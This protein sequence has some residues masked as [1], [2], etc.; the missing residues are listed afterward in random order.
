MYYDPYDRPKRRRS[1][2]LGWLLKTLFKLIALLLVLTIL[3]AG[4]LY[5]APISL[6]Q[7]EPDADVSPAADLPDSP[8]NLLIL[9]VDTLNNGL[10]RSDTMMI[11]SVG[12]NNLVLSSLQ[13]DVLVDL[14]GHGSCKL[15][16]AYAF[17]GAPMAMRAVN[18]TY[19][20]NVVRYIVV[21]FTV[22]VRIVDAIGGID[23]DIT[24]AEMQQINLNV[25]AS[26]PIF[27]PLGYTAQPL[28]TWG[29]KTHL[30]GLQA[31]GYARIRKIDSDFMRTSRQRRVITA[32][33]G[34][35]KAN[36][37]NPLVIIPTA[38]TV[39]EGIDTDLNF[40][41][42]VMVAEKV[43]SAKEITQLRLPVDGS[44]SDNG[45]SL[46]I[47]DYDASARAF[48]QAVYQ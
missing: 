5:I 36:L 4:V 9:G 30:D 10:Q 20:T 40:V 16:A 41:E 23:I 15:N 44:F 47:T 26:Y 3:A 12:G 29:E 43:L 21:D 31:L 11:A 38:K 14:E 37:F 2:C 19:R 24:E 27:G 28:T 42:L 13:R 25:V 6:L 46:K 45:S 8:L 48:R 22:L 33:V 18:Q 1:G 17:G 34:K 39:M 7:V 35:L 32:I